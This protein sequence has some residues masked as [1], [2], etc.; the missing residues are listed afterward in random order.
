MQPTYSSQFIDGLRLNTQRPSYETTGYIW[1]KWKGDGKR[2]G[3]M[4]VD[5]PRDLSFLRLNPNVSH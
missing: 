1:R 5:H 3:A 4:V 2:I